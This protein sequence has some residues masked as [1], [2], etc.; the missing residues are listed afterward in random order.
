MATQRCRVDYRYDP[1]TTWLHWIT[2]ALIAILWVLGMTGD[3]F[4]RGPLRTG[5]WSMHVILGIATGFVLLTR[6]AWRAQFGRVLP[7]ADTGILHA[8]AVATHYAL[9]VFLAIV[10]VTGI[11]NASY[12]GTSLFDVWSVP[13]FGTGDAATRRSIND[14]HELAANLT[15]AVGLLHATAAPVDLPRFRGQLT[16]WDQATV[17]AVKVSSFFCLFCAATALF[18]ITRPPACGIAARDVL[19]C[20]QLFHVTVEALPPTGKFGGFWQPRRQCK[21]IDP[22]SFE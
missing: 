18:A 19:L 1:T 5:A 12:R 7:P 22:F 20:C 9:Y 6:I 8:T 11:L 3:W 14:W 16:S 4:P 21:F 17:S 2:V 13:K 15:L 10:V